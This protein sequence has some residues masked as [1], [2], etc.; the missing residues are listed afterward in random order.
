MNNV[1]TQNKTELKNKWNTRRTI[2]NLTF[3]DDF[4]IETYWCPELKDYVVD[5]KSSEAS[6]SSI[7]TSGQMLSLWQQIRTAILNDEVEK[8]NL[9]DCNEPQLNMFPLED[10]LEVEDEAV[11]TQQVGDE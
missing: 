5:F 8:I 9:D 4:N 2:L 11:S 1:N 3:N 10:V 7:L 6:D